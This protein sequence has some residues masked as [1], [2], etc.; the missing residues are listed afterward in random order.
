MI[1]K[2]KSVHIFIVMITF[3]ANSTHGCRLSK[4]NMFNINVLRDKQVS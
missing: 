1:R 4:G 2:S 3:H